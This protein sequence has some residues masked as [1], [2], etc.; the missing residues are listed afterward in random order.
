MDQ[1]RIKKQLR[2][3]NHKKIKRDRESKK[4]KTQMEESGVNFKN[5]FINL[6]I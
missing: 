1:T 5:L 2:T 4:T 3:A 6:Q